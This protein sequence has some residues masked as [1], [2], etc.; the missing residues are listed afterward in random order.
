VSE[1]YALLQSRYPSSPF[2]ASGRLAFAEAQIETG[3]ADEARRVLEPLVSS[4]SPEPR[5]WALLGKAR[6]ATGDRNG[7]LEAYARV[8]RDTA[9]TE[10]PR[11]AVLG[12]ARLLTAERRW[13]QARA[14]LD[15]LVKNGDAAQAAEAA[16]AM[17]ETYRGEG[18]QLAA[19]EYFLTAA[20]LAPE[21]MSGRRGLLA[22]GQT[23]AS[24]KQSDAA[25]ALYRKLLAQSNVPADLADAA[26]QGLTALGR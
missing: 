1:A 15:R 21:S 18:N 13:D 4:G 10:A 12:Q 22:A 6:E 8:A 19:A 11:D 26:R 9:G 7:A 5:A 20:Y 17:G 16:L 3:R 24:A 25:A 2:V 14:L 23:L